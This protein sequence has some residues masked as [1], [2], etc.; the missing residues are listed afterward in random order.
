VYTGKSEE[1]YSLMGTRFIA[2]NM[3]GSY[4]STVWKE[5][6]VALNLRHILFVY[7]NIQILSVILF[8]D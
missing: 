5:R 6:E 4:F 1:K 3:T 2:V 8:R 7:I